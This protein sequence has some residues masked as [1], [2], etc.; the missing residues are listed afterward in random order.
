MFS[1]LAAQ[2]LKPA[3]A[4]LAVLAVG[5][6]WATTYSTSQDFTETVTETGWTD[7]TGGTEATPVVFSATDETKGLTVSSGNLGLSS[8]Y[9]QISSGTYNI[10][11]SLFGTAGVM[12]FAGNYLN[13]SKYFQIGGATVNVTGGTIYTGRGTADDAN[14]R[15][16]AITVAQWADNNAALNI[17][18]GN[19]YSYGA[20]TNSDGI[21]YWM[22]LVIASGA[23]SV[24]EVTVSDWGRYDNANDTK[25]ASGS[26]SQGTLTVKD[27]G[28]FW[29]W[30]M[31]VAPTGQGFVNAAN[32]AT[33]HVN[34]TI[35]AGMGG[36]G[37]VNV[38]DSATFEVANFFVLGQAGT[39]NLNVTGGTVTI[40]NDLQL[41]TGEGATAT[42]TISGGSVS[43]TWDTLVGRGANSTAS[44]TVSGTA[45]VEVGRTLVLAWDTGSTGTL[46]LN[47][48]TFKCNYIDA[49]TGTAM[50]NFNGGTLVKDDSDDTY[51]PRTQAAA[52]TD[53]FI[54]D[55]TSVEVGSNGGTIDTNGRSITT[56]ASFTGT[57]T[58]RII[59]GGSVNFTATPTCTV[60]A[61][62]D[63]TVTGAGNVASTEAVSIV[64]PSAD[65][66]SKTLPT[67]AGVKTVITG[68]WAT[69]AN[70]GASYQQTLGSDTAY[71]SIVNVEDSASDAKISG[72]TSSVSSSTSLSGFDVYT[73][74]KGTLQ[75]AYG[76]TASATDAYIGYTGNTLTC[77]NGDATV[78][79]VA[80]AGCDIS[81]WSEM[82]GNAGVVIEDGASVLGS[83]VGSWIE[84]GSSQA[85]LNGNTAI[86]V[87][88]VL[89]TNGE[90]LGDDRD[91]KA[92]LY[93]IIGGGAAFTDNGARAP[94][95]GNTSITVS[96]GN[97]KSGTFAKAIVGGT[98]Q[99]RNHTSAQAQYLTGSTSITIN[100][101]NTVTFSAPIIG[102]GFGVRK[103]SSVSGN[104]NILINGGTFTG[105]IYAGGWGI[106]DACT[107][108]GDATITINGGIFSNA[109]FYGSS[110]SGTKT[111]AFTGNVDVSSA[112]ISGFDKITISKG[113][114]VTI[115][116]SQA[117]MFTAQGLAV[118]EDGGVYT[119]TYV[120]RYYWTPGTTNT[121][122]DNP[123][124]W[125]VG[126]DRATTET[127][128][129]T[130]DTVEFPSTGAPWTVT[131]TS[132]PTVAVV[133]ADG[134]VTF[135]GAQIYTS[136][137]TGTGTVTLAG[138]A[139]FHGYDYINATLSITA[140]LNV[141]GTGNKLAMYGKGSG[142]GYGGGNLSFTGD[143]TGNGEISIEGIRSEF[144]FS[145]NWQTFSGTVNV[146]DNGGSLHRNGTKL[147]ATKSSSALAKWNVYNADNRC[148]V[149][150]GATYEFGELTGVVRQN[151][152]NSKGK[153]TIKVGA[154]DTS[155]AL[156]YI[157]NGDNADRRDTIIKTGTGTMTLDATYVD[158]Y[159]IEGGCLLLTT[160]ASMPTVGGI[161]FKADGT[162][163]GLGDSMTAD[164]SSKISV[165]SGV[166][167]AISNATERTFETAIG[168][169]TT[170]GFTKKGTGTLTLKVAPTYT[171]ATT[172]EA[173]VLYVIDGDYTLTLDAST[174][175]VASDK[176]GYRKFVPA[177]ASV[178]NVAVEY[179]TDFATASVTMAL[180]GTGVD[181]K[182]YT[183]TVGEN[184]YNATAENG[185]VTF[186]NVDTGHSTAYDSFSY[187]VSSDDVTVSGGSG[188]KTIADE[189]AWFQSNSTTTEGGAWKDDLSWPEGKATVG[190]GNQ[191]TPTAASSASVVDVTLRVC[192]GDV[193]NDAIELADAKAAV[194]IAMVNDSPVF[195]ALYNGS[196]ETLTGDTPD[197]AATYTVALRLDYVNHRY[198]V[199]IGGT[200]MTYNESQWLAMP[201]D[202]TA[203]T[204]VAF[205]GQGTLTSLVG[206]Q[207]EGYVAMDAVGNRYVSLGAAMI[208][209]AS[210][211]SK[212][213]LT[214][215]HD[216]TFGNETYAK[217]KQVL[218]TGVNNVSITAA[219]QDVANA[220]VANMDI[221]LTSAQVTQGLKKDYYKAVATKNGDTNTYTLSIELDE[222]EVAPT[223]ADGTNKA[224]ETTETGV[225]F[226]VVDA[227]V[228]LYY[229]IAAG[230]SSNLGLSDVSGDMEK[231]DADGSLKLSNAALPTSGVKYYKVIVSDEPKSNN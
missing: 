129:G 80:G 27:N 168:S 11:D 229:G 20:G 48:G 18:G 89:D 29:N 122:W 88:S 75:G 39:G 164:P 190:D 166:S 54:A 66:A 65:W 177:Y 143:M 93:Y 198:S 7:V 58:L 82:T 97:E 43:S 64:A 167:F 33:L 185:S 140:N 155:F 192:F 16:G 137:V 22:G 96:L 183:L 139:G 109:K 92:P 184:A 15:C 153:S 134:N 30:T 175:E 103:G 225:S 62:A 56:G 215:L 67:T 169:G 73:I 102:G 105:A 220:A 187:T 34:G 148:F 202:A 23:N 217:S 214:V 104:S 118:E 172:V 35:T 212:L 19:V 14:P 9:W 45:N 112:T 218:P 206:T 124:N 52:G 37:T 55:G 149:A 204:A 119:A 76:V 36:T 47:G 162:V 21:D 226:N 10:T 224:M 131:L 147:N 59:G 94:I 116:S 101:P 219:S 110:A 227:K 12:N 154:L 221:V 163:L 230:D 159:Q 5:G 81:K 145:G 60:V 114:T 208:G 141:T 165:D 201:N 180:E 179:G 53:K 197:P 68:N 32:N 24:G 3:F 194:K 42:A 150:N 161:A 120:E 182:A 98:A 130:S 57:G 111:L 213:P 151:Y 231:C 132:A 1:R 72:V 135:S 157:G 63:T 28:Y 152:N 133:I 87:K 176:D 195:Q 79:T 144:T 99:L 26:S 6:A 100:A 199:N 86:L 61:D 38:S 106:V 171:G 207:S 125:R 74:V 83:V 228:G 4:I 71:V 50:I 223:V 136:S 209:V 41:A 31:E 200:Q 191:F 211:S 8:G 70:G 2:C 210:D 178:G 146:V 44:L 90:T 69:Y 188:S 49:G 121:N 203:M 13:V 193:N 113:V 170:G 128:P 156:T 51:S 84:T 160:D 196:F 91:S 108:A 222:T 189:A 123:E 127:A 142:T 46:N 186:E 173:G 181:G 78:T 115:S 138:N 25:I 40:G 85:K 117:S 107:V 95:S 126:D 158:N 216:G 17:S 205:Q 77:I 174:A